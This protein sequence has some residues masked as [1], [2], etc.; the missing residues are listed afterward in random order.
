MGIERNPDELYDFIHVHGE[1]CKCYICKSGNSEETPH[2]VF[3][4]SDGVEDMLTMP[5]EVGEELPCQDQNGVV[6]YIKRIK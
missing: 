3:I 4:R 1:A 6:Y 5:S 2:I